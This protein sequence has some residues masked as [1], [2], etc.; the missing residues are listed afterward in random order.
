MFR[1]VPRASLSP[2]RGRA[3]V[4]PAP[5]AVGGAPA[6]GPPGVPEGTEGVLAPSSL[7]LEGA[8]AVSAVEGLGGLSWSRGGKGG[9]CLS[10][11][12]TPVWGPQPS[13][14]LPPPGRWTQGLVTAVLAL[15]GPAGWS[16]PASHL[17]GTGEGSPVPARSASELR[18][19]TRTPEPC[20]PPSLSGHPKALCPQ[21]WAKGQGAAAG[22]H[23]APPSPHHAGQTSIIR[24]WHLAL[25]TR[26]PRR[27][28]SLP[29]AGR[30]ARVRGG[31]PPPACSRLRGLTAWAPPGL[32]AQAARLQPPATPGGW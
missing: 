15:S 24:F 21:G 20:R 11:G 6:A 4:P 29:R 25:C 13:A 28:L 23:G 26:T 30:A 22:T 19:R 3:L 7:L 14:R 9:S 2:E 18:P 10:A 5:S 1:L 32:A 8:G 17:G 31:P 12:C 27:L 16:A